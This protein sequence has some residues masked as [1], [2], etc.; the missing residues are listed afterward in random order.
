MISVPNASSFQ[1]KWYG[2]KYAYY[3]SPS[4]LHQFSSKSLDVLLGR[5]GFFRKKDFIVYQYQLFGHIQGLHNAIFPKHNY[6]YYRKKRGEN[7]G[8]RKREL[9]VLDF[10]SYACLAVCVPVG[11]VLSIVDILSA[12]SRGVITRCFKKKK[13]N[14]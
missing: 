2:K 5:Y 6:L 7:F 9:F 12:D 3:D 11:L 13:F 8:L 1:Y 10:Y 14:S 4:H